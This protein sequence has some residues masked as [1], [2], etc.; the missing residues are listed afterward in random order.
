[1]ERA[2][3]R[4]AMPGRLWADGGTGELIEELPYVFVEGVGGGLV[5]PPM[6]TAFA[7]LAA[8]GLGGL[9]SEPVVR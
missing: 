2:W 1:M 5:S 6:A 7:V 8:L 3:T 9:G 4:N